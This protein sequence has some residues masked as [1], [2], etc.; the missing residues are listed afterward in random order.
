MLAAVR[1]FLGEWVVPSGY[2][3]LREQI[4]LK[5]SMRLTAAEAAILARNA[6]FRNM[7][8]GRRCFV[9]G[10]GPSLGKQDLTPLGNEI[11]IVMN[12]FSRHPIIEKWKPTFFCMADP[13]EN[14]KRV[15][16]SPFLD[17]IEAQAYFFQIGVKEI[18]DGHRFVAPGTV[19]YFKMGSA[20]LNYWMS[21]KRG[22]DF[23]RTIPRC[24]TTAHIALMLAVYL[25]C[26]PI[27]L[28]GLDHDWLAHSVGRHFYPESDDLTKLSYKQKVQGTLDAWELYEWIQVVA[29]KQG[30]T[31]HNTTAGGFLDV[32]PRIEYES[33]FSPR[34]DAGANHK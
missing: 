33:L 23:T 17:R 20:P 2:I 32:F 19:F 9:I 24:L 34:A 31:I 14:I 7:Y 30:I 12:A 3:R 11:T 16:L 4:A 15:G 29:K 6:R 10:N 13:A 28:L 27:Y 18:F 26:S 22:I 1:R 25:G 21:A 8:A 5:R